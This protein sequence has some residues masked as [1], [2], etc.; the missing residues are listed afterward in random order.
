MK[1]NALRGLSRKAPLAAVILAPALAASQASA[2]SVALRLERTSLKNV[3]DDAGRFQHEGGNVKKGNTIIGQYLIMRRVTLPA[4]STLNTAATTITLFI[5]TSNT[6]APSCITLQGA[7]NFSAGNFRGGVSA[8]SNRYAFL[9][10]AD[11]TYTSPQ[12][13][14]ET[15]VMSWNGSSQL[16]VP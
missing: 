1:T 13:G 5:G 12:S 4:T 3:D 2:G 15:L 14:V 11:A 9:N 6:T 10:G 16:T 8:A 7:H